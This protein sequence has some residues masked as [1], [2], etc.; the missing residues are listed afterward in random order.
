MIKELLS[1]AIGVDVAK[2]ERGGHPGARKLPYP[3]VQV[4]PGG[5]RQ[6]NTAAMLDLI[7]GRRLVFES[8]L[9]REDLMTRLAQQVAPPRLL[10]R[11][12][13]PQLFEGT[14]AE[15]RFRMMR[16]VRGRNS[17]RPVISG[18]VTA[19]TGGARLDVRLQL[20][21]IVVVICAVLLLIGGLIA[22]IAIPEYLTTGSSPGL[23][24]VIGITGVYVAF[25]IATAVEARRATRMLAAL[26]AA[27]P[28]RG[29]AI[30]RQ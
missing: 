6:H 26:F 21:P 5:S 3:P 14:I 7:F 13:G 24:F 16:S 12:K 23:L 19:G 17:F 28:L 27:E 11:E 30:V 9:T 1:I 25:A 8:P 10:S 4:R 18:A 20:H 22:S 29:G 15:G 2:L